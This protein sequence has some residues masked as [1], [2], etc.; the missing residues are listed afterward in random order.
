MLYI[1]AKFH[2]DTI[3]L[4]LR[5]LVTFIQIFAFMTILEYD[6]Y[7]IFFLLHFCD[8]RIIF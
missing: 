5:F 3:S 2:L 1:R 6:F 8:S 4:F 7:I